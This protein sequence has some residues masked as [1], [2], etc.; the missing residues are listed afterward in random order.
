MRAELP[1]PISLSALVALTA[2]LLVV[3][4]LISRRFS[5]LALDM[6]N[7][8]SMHQ[9]VVPRSGGLGILIGASAGFG[10]WYL[11][12]GADVTPLRL[13]GVGLGLGV[14]SFLDDRRGL[15]ILVRFA[16]Q[17]LAAALAAYWVLHAQLLWLVGATFAIAWMTNLY[18][19]MDG[20]DGLAGGMAC[21]GFASYALA[22]SGDAGL[23]TLFVSVAA[24]AL[25]FLVFNL[26][27]A[28]IFM[29][30]VGSTVLGYLAAAFGLYGHA[31]GRWP[32]WFPLL[33][34]AP[35]VADA[36]VTL[37][38]RGL[39]GERVWQAHR[40]HYYQRLIRSGW[41]HR[42]MAATAYVLIF[43]SNLTAQLALRFAPGAGWLLLAGWVVLLGLLM[44]AVER[45][46]ARHLG[47]ASLTHVPD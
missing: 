33:A 47:G 34:F 43:A 9:A 22:S 13:W 6:P 10:F 11:R 36:S 42:R 18:N 37:A 23:T 8:R 24:A 5:S 38:A 14:L 2:S 4:A 29:G 28:R 32:L 30:D 25:G 1:V 41:S 20:S 35:F 3:R 39:R 15:P 27:P 26:P 40:E 21:L 45:R 44:L 12:H 46:W 16:G 31:V 7:E 17:L 19:F